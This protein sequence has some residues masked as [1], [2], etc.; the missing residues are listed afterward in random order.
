MAIVVVSVALLFPA[1]G[2]VSELLAET[3]VEIFAFIPL[4]T[5]TLIVKLASLPDAM[6]PSVHV[7]LPLGSSAHP[8][9]ETN[10]TPAGSVTVATVLVA[11]LGP[12]LSTVA[13][14]AKLSPPVTGSKESL[15]LTDKSAVAWMTVS[16][17]V[18]L[19][20][21]VFVS[22]TD[23]AMV[24]VFDKVPLALLSTVQTAV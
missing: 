14:K 11:A 16:L 9:V 23:E 5:V 1:T 17:S 22:V 3:V 18:A 20:L 12:R 7:G 21:P 13:V 8:L 24:A 4:S 2:S 15:K 19:L 10:V 6:F